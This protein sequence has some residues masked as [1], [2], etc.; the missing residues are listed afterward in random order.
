MFKKKEFHSMLL[1]LLLSAHALHYYADAEEERCFTE[2]LPI[3]TSIVGS[4]KADLWD[5]QKTAFG[6][7]KGLKLA[8]AV[9]H[10]AT[11]HDLVK[12]TN[13]PKGKFRFTAT[14]PGV[15]RLCL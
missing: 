1:L 11:N 14:D 15:H 13:T 9:T 5:N 4:Y 6:D 12:T 7:A 8:V 2:E 10:V 3:A